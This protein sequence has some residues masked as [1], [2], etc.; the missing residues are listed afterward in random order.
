MEEIQMDLSVCSYYLTDEIKLIDNGRPLDFYSF[1][2]IMWSIGG[3]HDQ[4]WREREIFGKIRYMNYDGC[5]RKFDIAEYISRYGG[6]AT[7]ST[8]AQ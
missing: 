3:V 7:P 6:K 4:G 1:L 5:K 8:S 2:G